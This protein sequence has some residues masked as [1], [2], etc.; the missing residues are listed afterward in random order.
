MS[1]LYANYCLFTK[2]CNPPGYALAFC[3]LCMYNKVRMMETIHNNKY[4]H[5]QPCIVKHELEGLI[6][7]DYVFCFCFI[8]LLKPC[9]IATRLSTSV[10]K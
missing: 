8:S 1:C 7:A 4:G 5:K 2:V 3:N 10:K 9:M 6:D